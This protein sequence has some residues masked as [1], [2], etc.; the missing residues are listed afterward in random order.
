MKKLSLLYAIMA[1]MLLSAFTVS[2][3]ITTVDTFSGINPT[4]GSDS[5]EASNPRHDEVA[6]RLKTDDASIN[7]RSDVD[8]TITGIQ[9]VSNSPFTEND[10]QINLT[11]SDLTL[12]A[13]VAETIDFRARIPEKLDA[14]DANGEPLAFAVATVKLFNGVT[15]VGSFVAFMQRENNLEMSN[16]DATIENGRK[17]SLSDDDT[18]ENLKPGDRVDIE[19]EASNN[20]QDESNTDV[21]SVTLEIECDNDN[22]FDFDDKNVDIGDIAPEDEQTDS[23]SLTIESDAEDKDSD[24]LV[25][26]I[27]RDQNGARHGE[28]TNFKMEVTRESHDIQIT[29]ATI[30]P[31]SLTCTDREMQLTVDMLNLGRSNEDRVALEVTSKAISFQER[32]SNIELDEDDSA[33]EIFVIPVNAE[34]LKQGPFAIQVQTFYDNTRSSDTETVQVD[35]L[36]G[37]QTTGNGNNGPTPG[38]VVQGALELDTESIQMNMGASAS[39][40]V[41]VNNLENTPVEYTVTLADTAEFAEGTA[42]KTVFLNPGQQSTV[43]LNLRA[44]DDIDTGKYSGIIVLKDNAGKTLETK[45]FTVDVTERQRSSFSFGKIFGDSDSRIFWIIG[46]IILIIVAIFFIRLIFTG[47]KKKQQPTNKKLADYE[48]EMSKKKTSRRRK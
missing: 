37:T 2:A 27:G 16:L 10:L 40:A 3:T 9:I 19:A 34:T 45:T 47:G 14:V 6:Q 12:A 18:L 1:V 30:N 5:Q 46:D 33:Q 15:E 39:I 8:V 29:A 21:E 22:N 31:T 41:K 28:G 43:L 48:A 44:K 24:C 20:Y 26:L 25:K 32:V 4:F 35:N 13:G 42:T 38:P 36:C 11:D 23:L 7:L 17:K